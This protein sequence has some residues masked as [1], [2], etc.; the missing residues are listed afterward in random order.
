MAAEVH[1]AC[2]HDYFERYSEMIHG[3]MK[4]SAWEQQMFLPPHIGTGSVTRMRVREGMEIMVTDVTYAED[5]RLCIQ[6]ACRLFELSYCLSGEVYCEWSGKESYTEPQSGNVLLLEDVRV[7]E[8]KKAGMHHHMVEVRFSPDELY[9]YAVDAAEKQNMERLL[10]R[11][12]GSIDTYSVTPDIHRCVTDM[13]QCDYQGKM[14]RLYMES[15]AIEFLALFGE[16][17]EI[18]DRTVK[19]N[20]RRDDI[21]KLHEA[22]EIVM[23]NYEQPFSIRELSKLVGINEFKLKTGFRELFDTTVFE[24]VRKQR[25][26]K[27]IWHMEMEHL[28]V[29]EAAVAVGYSNVSNFTAAFRKHYGCN[30]SSFLKQLEQQDQVRRSSSN[31]G[32]ASISQGNPLA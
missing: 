17:D 28:N 4:S 3:D 10:H 20:V 25:I 13:L 23:N 29:G 6:E 5:M 19:R 32:D 9:A 30:P 21:A 14:K 31:G 27:A 26:E 18:H 1:V 16:A 15:K 22:R 2:I 8:E 12:L 11:H 7:Y 24:L